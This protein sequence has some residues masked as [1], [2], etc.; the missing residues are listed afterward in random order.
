MMLELPE[1][2][3]ARHV[4]RTAFA[5]RVV[6]LPMVLIAGLLV[7]AAVLGWLSFREQTALRVRYQQEAR[8]DW[9]SNPDKHP[10]RMAHFGNFAFRPKPP[11]SLFEFGMES[12]LGNLVF[13]EAHKQNSVNFS[14]AGFSTGLLRFGEISLAMVL[15]LLLP[16]LIFFLGYGV[17]AAERDSGTLRL[18]LSQG[19]SPRQL[20][21]G[22]MRGLVGVVMRLYV[23]VVLLTVVGWLVLQNGRVSAD[24]TARL[25]LLMLAYAGYLVICCGVAVLVSARSSSARTA[26]VT[27]MGIWLMLTIVLPRAAQAVGAYVYEIPS[28]AQFFA[29]IQDDVLKEGDSHNPAD[30]HY[31]KLKDSLLTAYNV[32]SV[33]QLPVNYSGVVMA[34]GEKISAHIYTNH[35]DQLQQVYA[36]QN[37]LSELVA[38]VDPFLAIR[39]LSMALAGTDYATYA[40]FQQ[41]AE[42]YRYEMAQYLNAL[43]IKYIP[44]KK[45]GPTDKPHAISRANWEAMP[46]FTYQPVPVGVTLTQSWRS[47]VALVVWLVGLVV[48]F[49]WVA[50]TF[51]VA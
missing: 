34:E 19:I 4:R 47:L 2:I 38:F 32:D 12:Y 7:Y 10:H 3:L 50:R 33:Q 29:R 1:R 49:R 41:Q 11:L 9:L 45:A 14:E 42:H 27:L 46:D 43:Q 18:L 13:L 25:L 31:A 48:A 23:P 35:F 30:P 40:D 6:W 24:E 37:R 36:R 39:Q 8:H 44:N 16:L 51:T 20:L 26:L 5:S 17:V 28:K 15:Q 21:V 22:K